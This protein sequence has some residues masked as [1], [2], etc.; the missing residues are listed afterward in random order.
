MYT[1]L[2]KYQCGGCGND[3][4]EIYQEEDNKQRLITECTQCKSQ[5]EITITPVQISLKWGESGNGMMCIF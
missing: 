1:N 4:Y 3:K 5:T 2:Q